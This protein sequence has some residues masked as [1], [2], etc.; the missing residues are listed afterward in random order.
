MDRI[1]LEDVM[2]GAKELRSLKGM[3]YG[4]M[5]IHYIFRVAASRLKD[6]GIEC[7]VTYWEKLDQVEASISGKG[8]VEVMLMSVGPPNRRFTFTTVEVE[9]RHYIF[10]DGTDSKVAYTSRNYKLYQRLQDV[11]EAILK[12]ARMKPPFAAVEWNSGPGWLISILRPKGELG[13]EAVLLLSVFARLIDTTL[14][15]DI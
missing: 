12:A 9:D 6:K 15:V 10:I 7:N 14:I 11:P 13:Q 5:G 3:R 4:L 8:C 2:E 1:P